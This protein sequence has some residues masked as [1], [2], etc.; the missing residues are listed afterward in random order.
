M[1]VIFLKILL[2]IILRINTMRPPRCIIPRSFK[3][4]PVVEPIRH[5]IPEFN[6]IRDN[7]PAAPLGGAGHILSFLLR[8][9]RREAVLKKSPIR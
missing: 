6:M 2:K 3:H 5:I 1:L 9:N 7:P 8:R 4:H